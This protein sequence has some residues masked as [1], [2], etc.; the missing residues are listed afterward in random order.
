MEKLL[1]KNFLLQS[2]YRV[3]AKASAFQVPP[4]HQQNSGNLAR[5]LLI[6]IGSHLR[7][8]LPGSRSKSTSI[9]LIEKCSSH[10]THLL[11]ICI[12]NWSSGVHCDESKLMDRLVSLLLRCSVVIPL[13]QSPETNFGKIFPLQQHRKRWNT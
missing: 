8:R 3:T 12:G 13:L 6:K 4:S 10:L 1:S 5:M 7:L 2:G 9:K 11:E